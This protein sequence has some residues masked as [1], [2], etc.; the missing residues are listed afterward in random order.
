MFFSL[1]PPPNSC[2]SKVVSVGFHSTLGLTSVSGRILQWIV[3]ISVAWEFIQVDTVQ[4]TTLCLCLVRRFSALADIQLLVHPI[5]ARAH[6][7]AA[8]HKNRHIAISR[9]P[10]VVFCFFGKFWIL[11]GILDF[12]VI[13]LD[14]SN[15]PSN[16]CIL[17][18]FT[19][20]ERPKGVKDEVKQAQ[21]AHSRPKGRYLRLLVIL[22]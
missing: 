1:V 4:W 18:W 5:P 15:V 14:F 10:R 8:C 11:G 19:W 2:K 16:H 22:S 17:A 21:R 13:F 7:A 20:P 12:S 6:A 3:M 9:E